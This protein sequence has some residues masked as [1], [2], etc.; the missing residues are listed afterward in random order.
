MR[1][2][3]RLRARIDGTLAAIRAHP[4]GRVAF[5]VAVA[6]LGALVVGLGLVLIPLPGPGW[7]LVLLGLAI[8]AVEFVW[9]KHLLRYT[10]HR[11]QLWTGWATSRSLPVRLLL[12]AAGLL[13]VGTVALLS[14][15]YGLG[16]DVIADGWR[17]ITTH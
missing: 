6:V 13:F 9:A 7:A 8:W 11:V 1:R 12:G 15:R 4:T 16:I 3:H 2:F 10:R 17:Y 14:L 5:K